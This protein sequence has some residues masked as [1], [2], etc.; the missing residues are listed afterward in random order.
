MEVASK[1]ERILIHC[2]LQCKKDV[3]PR[4]LAGVGRS[5]LTAAQIIAKGRRQ[6]GL[7]RPFRW[8]LPRTQRFR[9]RLGSGFVFVH[10]LRIRSD[11][12][13][14]KVTRAFRDLTSAVQSGGWRSLTLTASAGGPGKRFAAVAQW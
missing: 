2:V 10:V 1:W 7:P 9:R 8:I 11:G 4:A 6:A 14:V 13:L 12:A 5:G 3:C